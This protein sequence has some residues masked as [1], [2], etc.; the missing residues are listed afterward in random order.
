MDETAAAD[1]VRTT[2]VLLTPERP[3]TRNGGTA[4]TVTEVPVGDARDPRTNGDPTRDTART[5][6]PL[7][8]RRG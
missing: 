7:G 5:D 3:I 4:E 1:P 2:G 8:A 6:L